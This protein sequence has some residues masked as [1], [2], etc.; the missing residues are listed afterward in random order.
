MIRAKKKRKQR[1]FKMRPRV[2]VAG[3][4]LFIVL[5]IGG[6][7]GDTEAKDLGSYGPTFDIV[8]ENFLVRIQEKL[9]VLEKSGKMKDHQLELTKRV[10]ERV[11]R[12]VPVGGLTVV[13]KNS[14]KEYDPTFILDQDIKDHEGNL[15]GKKGAIYNPLDY[16]PFGVP[17]FFIDGDDA[18]Q[19]SWALSGQGKIVL[20]KG[21]PLTLFKEFQHQF[22]FDQG[23]SIVKKFG[24]DQIPAKVSQEGKKLKIEFIKL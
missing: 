17:L 18:N 12:P 21:S 9:A 3:F 14:V 2:S 19:V 22:F 10:K 8:E 24:I 6:R 7:G 20:I 1:G 13:T 11:L 5:L 4:I 23:G 16:R 15:I